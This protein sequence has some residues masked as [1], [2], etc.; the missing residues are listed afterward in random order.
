LLFE[1]RRGCFRCVF[2]GFLIFTRSWSDRTRHDNRF[3]Q[4]EGL[5]AGKGVVFAGVADHHR[6]AVRVWGC[7]LVTSLRKGI[8]LF[9]GPT[10][11][12]VERVKTTMRQMIAAS[13]VI[14]RLAEGTHIW[15][16]Q[17]R[18]VLLYPRGPILVFLDG[19]CL[20]FGAAALGVRRL[21]LGISSDT[22]PKEVAL[23]I[24]PGWSASLP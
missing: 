8:I 12:F 9:V 13:R 6:I 2:E 4:V 14:E 16:E 11:S 22:E 18:L 23:L 17:K 7:L 10:I 5:A 15:R 19:I 1:F 20:I 24:D 3:S 21:I